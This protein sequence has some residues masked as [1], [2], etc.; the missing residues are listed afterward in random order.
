MGKREMCS[1]LYN[2]QYT[3]HDHPQA[4]KA[5]ISSN[6]D[7]DRIQH[8]KFRSWQNSKTPAHNISYKNNA[9]CFIL[10]LIKLWWVMAKLKLDKFI[11]LCKRSPR[12]HPSQHWCSI[13][14][15]LE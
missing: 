5:I 6:C 15:K 4:R 3:T 8:R 11:S 9:V 2:V 10:S 12:D 13:T 7:L 14:I 1:D